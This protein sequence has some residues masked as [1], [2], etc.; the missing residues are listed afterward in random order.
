VGIDY[1]QLLYTS[2]MNF[3]KRHSTTTVKELAS[4]YLD[5]WLVISFGIWNRHSFF[6]EVRVED[7]LKEHQICDELMQN[8][9]T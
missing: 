8:L 4:G 1:N 3:R 6:T 2:S 5:D 7:V 9:Q